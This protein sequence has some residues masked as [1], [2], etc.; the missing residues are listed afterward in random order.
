[1]PKHPPQGRKPP[2]LT[3]ALVDLRHRG[4]AV[5]PTHWLSQLRANQVETR[6]R[7]HGG[8]RRALASL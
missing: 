1:M 4:Q 7:Q 6:R 5:E 3:R 8:H 2:C